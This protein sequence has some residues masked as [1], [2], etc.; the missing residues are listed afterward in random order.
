M[1]GRRTEKL[2]YKF[3]INLEKIWMEA[4]IFAKIK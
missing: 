4:Q 3:Y 2:E 1:V